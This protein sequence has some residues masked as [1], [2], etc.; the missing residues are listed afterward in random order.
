MLSYLINPN[1][2]FHKEPTKTVFAENLQIGDKIVFG[3]GVSEVKTVKTEEGITYITYTDSTHTHQI[4][5]KHIFNVM[6]S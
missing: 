4:D 2:D 6:I 1:S 5:A 3:N